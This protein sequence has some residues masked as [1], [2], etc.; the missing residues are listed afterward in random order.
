MISTQVPASFGEDF[1]PLDCLI[2]N[3]GT[4]CW[5]SSWSRRVGFHWFITTKFQRL[6]MLCVSGSSCGWNQWRGAADAMDWVEGRKHIVNKATKCM[7]LINRC[8]KKAWWARP[9]R[10]LDKAQADVAVGVDL[11]DHY[12][13]SKFCGRSVRFRST[14]DGEEVAVAADVVVLATG[15]RQTFPFL[16]RASDGLDDALPT[17][18]FIC[19]PDEP[20]LAFFGFARPNVGAIPPMAE[21]QAMWWVAK[22]QGRAT[23]PRVPSAPY[24]LT[25]CRLSYGVDYGLYMFS[26]AREIGAA[27]NLARWLLER[28]AVALACAFGQAHAPLFRLDGPFARDDAADV[29]A[30]ELL[31]PIRMRGA[32]MNCIFGLTLCFFAAVNACAVVIEGVVESLFPQHE[33]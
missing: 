28:P 18:H 4:H 10:W 5:E 20:D 23:G 17:E 11:L 33:E 32:A 8:V 13:A 19:D 7:P 3:A 22:L 31:E 15:Y 29:C 24:K 12:E 6:G 25:N 9:W 2:A 30:T 27:P 16:K 26:L 1:A 21:L 14:R